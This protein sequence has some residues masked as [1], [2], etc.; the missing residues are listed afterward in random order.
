M[1]TIFASPKPFAG[2][3][4]T[5]QRNAISSWVRLHPQCQVI[6]FGD[7]AGIAGAAE[8]FGLRHVPQVARNNYGTPLLSDVFE[9]AAGLA[10]HDL[11]CYVNCDI[12]LMSDFMRAVNNLAERK[13]RFLMVGQC[14]NLD[15][16][17]PI[18][19]DAPEWERRLQESVSQSG[20]WRGPWAIDYF[21]F[22]RGLYERIPPFA[23]GRA[24]FDNWLVWR[25]RDLRA[26]VADATSAVMAVHQNHDYAH[27][28][29]GM[30]W[31]YRGEEAKRNLDLG[32]NHVCN[33]FDATYRLTPDR[34][35]LNWK[36]RFPFASLR[37]L[38]WPI[39][40]L[41]TPW[42]LQALEITRPVRRPLGLRMANFGRLKA[43][44]IRRK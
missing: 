41:V 34:L 43:A 26:A 42:W 11:L 6:L 12:I 4:G 23:L 19:F 17:E 16:T 28:S 9:K 39:K 35:R 14:R 44:L 24:H 29:G 8:E 3:I 31:S 18:V 22:T 21:A 36:G 37:H 33:I 32:G 2:H 40:R 15:V 27:V 13:E 25:G 7:E 38:G 5:I 30:D 1:I 20:K 10:T